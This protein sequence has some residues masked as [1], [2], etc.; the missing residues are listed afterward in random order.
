MTLDENSA[1]E[2]AAQLVIRSEAIEEAIRRGLLSFVE[3][4]NSPCWRFGDSR[5][6]SFRRLDGEPFRINGQRVKA[7]AETKGNA[8]HQ[9]IGLADVVEHDRRFVIFVLEGSRDALA[10]LELAHRAGLLCQVGIVMALG[11]GY[12]SIPTELRQLSGRK[13]LLIGDRDDAG[14]AAVRRVSHALMQVG[15]D[16][17]VWNWNAFNPSFGKDLF[18]L[19]KADSQRKE[20]L[21]AKYLTFFSF[22]S[23]SYGSTVQQFNGSTHA[24]SSVPS[25]WFN[26]STHIQELVVPFVVKKR[27]TGNALSF[28]LART[29]RTYEVTNNAFLMDTEI[30]EIFQ[31][32]FRKSQ[33]LLPPDANEEK[34]LAHFYKQI[35]RV[36]YL[37]CA[38]DA[39]LE[40]A[41]ASPLPNIAGLSTNALKVAALMRE[42]QRDAGDKSFICPVNVIVKFVPLRFAE[43]AKRILL[44]LEKSG[45]IQCVERGRPHAPGVYGKSTVWRYTHSK[46]RATN[47]RC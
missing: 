7:E 31:H 13:V 26:S 3:H 36:R 28:A 33:P 43:Q 11:A 30:D 41:S 5:N 29:L 18:D 6:G 32:W 10:A 34:S 16:H 15:V 9:L 40:R 42:L 38:L 2:L 27:G 37:P 39:A 12:R 17:A 35:R 1:D 46:L 24:G 44:V 22:F 23:P 25:R 45:V 19:L 47:L 14:C 8:W 20:L 21:S 4:R